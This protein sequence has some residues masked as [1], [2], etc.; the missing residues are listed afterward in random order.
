[1]RIVS[2]V[3]FVQSPS[4]SFS[5]GPGSSR[6]SPTFIGIT[7]VSN[8]DIPPGIST[9]WREMSL[10]QGEPQKTPKA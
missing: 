9:L 7:I 4:M 2:T 8:S 10:R 1:M 5:T 3:A 6:D